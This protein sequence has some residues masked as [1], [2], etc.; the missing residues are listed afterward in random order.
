MDYINLINLTISRFVRHMMYSQ[1]KYLNLLL[2]LTQ[3]TEISVN[4]NIQK[5]PQR[6][7]ISE[8]HNT[9]LRKTDLTSAILAVIPSQGYHQQLFG[10]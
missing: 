7:L 8:F 3:P 4:E 2:L 1:T 6:H 9:D 5:F 10:E